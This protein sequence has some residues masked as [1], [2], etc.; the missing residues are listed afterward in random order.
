MLIV[1]RSISLLDYAWTDIIPVSLQTA[2]TIVDRYRKNKRAATKPSR[3]TYIRAKI[4][5]FSIQ[6]GHWI[7]TML[8]GRLLPNQKLQC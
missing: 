4:T 2:G 5:E 6:T 8:P 7:S 3:L 1:R